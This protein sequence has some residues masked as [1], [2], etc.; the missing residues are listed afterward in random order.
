MKIIKHTFFYYFFQNYFLKLI[1][2]IYF[3]KTKTHLI[4]YDYSNILKSEL[5]S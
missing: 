5:N 1:Y 2:K 3:K 4:K